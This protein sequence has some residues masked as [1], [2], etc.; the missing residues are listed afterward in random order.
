MFGSIRTYVDTGGDLSFAA[1]KEAMSDG[2]SFISGGPLIDFQ[3][4]DAGMGDTVRL[5]A[6]GGKVTVRA[7][8]HSPLALRDLVVVQ[9]GEDQDL[10]VR[11]RTINGINRWSIE[12]VVE[13]TESG[14]ISAWGRGVEIVAQGFDTRAHAGVVRVLVGDRPVRSPVDA[15]YFIDQFI[16]LKDFYLESGTYEAE[17]DRM[18]SIEL[19]DQAI[20]R[21][22]KQL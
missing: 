8:L 2:R 11:K 16:A 3:V 5:P 9:D 19:F 22:Q 1:F 15:Q 6:G 12:S 21:L 10:T 18:H 17:K 7:A 14:W 4:D 20:Q 13:V